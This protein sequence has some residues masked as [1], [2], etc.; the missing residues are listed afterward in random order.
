MISISNTK[1]LTN[2]TIVGSPNKV[3]DTF[4]LTPPLP[5]YLIAF[6]VSKYERNSEK[7]EFGVYARPGAKNATKVALDF[8][9]KMLDAFGVYLNISYYALGTTTKM[10][11]AAIPDFSAGGKEFRDIF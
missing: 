6:I 3:K 9:S 8:G 2:E 1:R 7:E 10:D 5:T 11:M 4:E